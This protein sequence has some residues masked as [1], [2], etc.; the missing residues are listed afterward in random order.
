MRSASV[1]LESALVD[2]IRETPDDDTPRLALADWLLDQPDPV[3]QARGEFIHLQC[4]TGDPSTPEGRARCER[5]EALRKEYQEAWLGG[6][7]SILGPDAWSFD[8]GLIS[9]KV[10]GAE[11]AS[12]SAVDLASLPGWRWVDDLV[13]DEDEAE[14]P[15]TW[16]DS[17]DLGGIVSLTCHGELAHKAV[18]VIVSGAMPHL[19]ALDL[20]ASLQDGEVQAIVSSP[21]MKQITRLTLVSLGI[22]LAGVNA[23]ARSSNVSCLQSLHLYPEGGSE[24]VLALALSPYLVAL[25]DLTLARCPFLDVSLSGDTAAAALARSIFASRLESL[26]FTELGIGP[27]GMAALTTSS[28][29]PRLTSLDLS[30]NPIGDRGIRLLASSSLERLRYLSLSECGITAKGAEVV[31][32]ASNLR[33]LNWLQLGNNALDSSAAAALASSQHLGQLDLL[34]LSWNQIR[35]R[36]AI[37]LASSPFL[38]R[39][40][41]LWLWGNPIGDPGKAALTGRFG[42]RVNWDP[43]A[44]PTSSSSP[45]PP[46]P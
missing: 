40:T 7:L 26:R 38:T 24:E 25:T 41:N 22:T 44:P 15:S 37:A 6:L 34:D 17:S 28:S 5:E 31:A 12:V 33:H 30:G 45:A 23:L 13:L 4:W 39:L 18:E 36:G 35:D 10:S 3:Q 2:A 16:F 9:L 46:S 8:R 42:A 14:A 19:C 29:L 43:F 32:G 27:V 20:T 1:D 21:T 11:L